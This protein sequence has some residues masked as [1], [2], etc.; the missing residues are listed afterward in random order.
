MSSMKLAVS[1]YTLLGIT[2]TIFLAKD[3][4]PAPDGPAI[5]TTVTPEFFCLKI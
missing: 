1:T 3:V 4:F 2:V 5:P